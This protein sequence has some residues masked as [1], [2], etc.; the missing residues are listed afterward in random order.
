MEKSIKNFEL[1]QGYILSREDNLAH[2][3]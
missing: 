2:A 3:G 1:T